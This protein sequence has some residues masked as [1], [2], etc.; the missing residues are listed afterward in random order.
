M[1]EIKDLS[2]EI[3]RKIE[4]IQG[5]V[6]SGE[7]ALLDLEL[8]PIFENIKDSLNI[9]NIDNYSITFKNSFH[10]LTQKF[11]EL[12]ILISNL[13]KKE[14]FI[15]YLKSNP[16]DLEVYELFNRCWIKPFNIESLSLNFLSR[17]DKKLR[18]EKGFPVLIESLEKLPTKHN[19]LLEVPELKFTEKI[20]KFYNMINKK[21]PC[22]FDEI[23]ENEQDQVEIYEK[24]VYI[25][26][27]LQ[28]GKIKYQ[29]ET[30]FLYI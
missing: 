29:K 12:K 24:F 9:N 23:F 8:V 5:K 1:E 10:L 22:S 21:L 6:L 14:G 26:H 17:S 30:N 15:R 27:L 20:M 3:N 4:E 19:F 13:D 28:L 18:K 11:E 16:D 2:E 25:L 7:V